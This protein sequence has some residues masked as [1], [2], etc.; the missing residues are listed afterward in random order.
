[1]LENNARLN[2]LMPYWN[3]YVYKRYRIYEKAL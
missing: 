1:M 2:T 3:A